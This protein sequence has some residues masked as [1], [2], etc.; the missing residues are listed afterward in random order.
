MLRSLERGTRGTGRALLAV[1]IAF[2]LDGCS[3]P[4]RS[5]QPQFKVLV[6]SKTAGFRHDSIPADPRG[7][8]NVLLTLHESTYSGGTMGADHPLAWCQTY[9][10]GRSWY[11]ENGHTKETYYETLYMYSPEFNMLPEL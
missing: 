2:V 10:G 3:E 4:I 8:V 7:V 9:D 6:F 1:S 5:L 11:T